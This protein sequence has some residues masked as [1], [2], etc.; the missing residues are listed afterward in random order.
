VSTTQLAGYR[1]SGAWREVDK[2]VMSG[3][4]SRALEFLLLITLSRCDDVDQA[5]LT[6][7]RTPQE[8][9]TDVGSLPV[10]FPPYAHTELLIYRWAIPQL[11]LGSP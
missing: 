10:P 1:D 7:R 6:G 4:A 2:N 11:S 8:L 3:E 9:F 5:S